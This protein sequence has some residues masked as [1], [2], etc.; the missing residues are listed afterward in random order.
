MVSPPH[1]LF[2][3]PSETIGFINRLREY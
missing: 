2:R 1:D 3:K